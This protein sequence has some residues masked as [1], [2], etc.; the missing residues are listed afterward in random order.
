MTLTCFET[1]RLQVRHLTQADLDGLTALCRDPLAMRYMDDGGLLTRAQCK[2]WIEICQAKYAE[3]GY[4]TSGIFDKAT[5]EFVGFCGVVRTPESDYDEII[6]AL[7][8]S[9]WGKGLATEVA[10]AMLSYV[11]TRSQL[12]AIHATIHHKNA[13][14]I[15]MMAKLGLRFVKDMPEDD[16][17]VTKLYVK[18]R[19]A[20]IPKPEAES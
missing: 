7:T 14:S 16:G 10:A 12:D 13:A 2:Q 18:E 4:G 6:Y 15:K 17:S 20:T 1:E 11:F 3:R 5:D 19:P 9:S 8:Q